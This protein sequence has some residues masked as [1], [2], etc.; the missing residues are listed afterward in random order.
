MDIIVQVNI[1]ITL[2]TVAKYLNQISMNVITTMVGVV[3]NAT[4][5]KEALTVYVV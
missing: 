4:T 5:L 3:R 2:N 1:L